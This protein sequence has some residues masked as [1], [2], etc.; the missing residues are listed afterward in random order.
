[1]NRLEIFITIALVLVGT[2]SPTSTTR[3]PPRK[4]G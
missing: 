2:S 3:F 4:T 1:L